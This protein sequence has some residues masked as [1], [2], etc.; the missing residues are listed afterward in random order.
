MCTTAVGVIFYP[1]QSKQSYFFSFKS[2]KEG[3][4][5]SSNDQS[6]IHSFGGRKQFIQQVLENERI[7]KVGYDFHQ[8]L[9]AFLYL[10]IEGNSHANLPRSAEILIH[11]VQWEW[12]VNALISS[13]LVGCGTL[14]SL[15]SF[16]S[17]W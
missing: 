4:S 6:A 15:H 2:T 7:T 17:P 13:W 14:S 10:E 11:V 12:L 9:Q 1:V 8:I 16:S 3:A 5:E